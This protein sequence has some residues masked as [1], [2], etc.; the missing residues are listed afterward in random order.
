[1]QWYLQRKHP[2]NSTSRPCLNSPFNPYDH[3]GDQH[4]LHYWTNAELQ[5]RTFLKSGKEGTKLPICSA[6]V[7][8]ERVCDEPKKHLRRRLVQTH[9]AYHG[10]VQHIFY[11]CF[12]SWKI[13]SSWTPRLRQVKIGISNITVVKRKL[14]QE[15]KFNLKIKSLLLQ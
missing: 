15:S 8:G 4:K 6:D 11:F 2:Q 3:F 14:Q 13:I 10:Q 7:H 9:N 1:M 5:I 12:C